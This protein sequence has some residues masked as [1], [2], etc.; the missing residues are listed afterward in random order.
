MGYLR[1]TPGTWSRWWLLMWAVIVSCLLAAVPGL[2]V[3]E[4]LSV[5]TVA[6]GVPETFAVLRQSDPYPPLTHV[7]RHF[8][9]QW[10]AFTLIYGA[11]GSI[12][13]HWLGFAQP[14]RMGALF[15][16]LG[17]LTSHFETVYE[18]RR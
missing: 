10:A 14:L 3:R 4:W 5:A 8:L 11:F 2:T 1:E 7:I 6:F 12:A 15:A 17:W 18:E 9:P 13:S 16:L